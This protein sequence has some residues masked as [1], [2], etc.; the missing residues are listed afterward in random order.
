MVSLGSVLFAA[1]VATAVV[2]WVNGGGGWS[3]TNRPAGA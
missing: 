1:V 2:R 3:D